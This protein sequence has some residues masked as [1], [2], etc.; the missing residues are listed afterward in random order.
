MS[1]VEIYN[2]VVEFLTAFWAWGRIDCEACDKLRLSSLGSD[3][4]AS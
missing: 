4:R 3:I 1:L 2:L